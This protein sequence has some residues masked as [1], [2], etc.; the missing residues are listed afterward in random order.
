M[1]GRMRWRR[2]LSMSS[3]QR[4]AAGREARRN[5]LISAEDAANLSDI[6]NVWQRVNRLKNRLTRP[7][8]RA[9]AGPDRSPRKG[10]RDDAVLAL[11]VGCTLRRRELAVLEIS[12]TFK[13]VRGAAGLRTSAQG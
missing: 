6:P 9:A 3:H 12:R 7:G 10:K 5:R 8:E 11:S 4:S 2:Q 1:S 13:N